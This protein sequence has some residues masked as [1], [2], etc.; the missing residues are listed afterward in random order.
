[1]P[2]AFTLTVTGWNAMTNVSEVDIIPPDGPYIVYNG[3]SIDDDILGDN[4]GQLDYGESS[5]LGM[6]LENVGIEL[7]DNITAF[8]SSADPLITIIQDEANFGN[9]P[10]NSTVTVDHAY[11][12][13]LSPAVV[14]G[15]F[16]P[17]TLTAN[18][19]IDTWESNFSIIAHAPNVQYS[20]L[21]IDDAVGGNGNGSLDPGESATLFVNVTN[22]GSSMMSGVS[23]ILSTTDPHVI[24]DN[25]TCE[26]LLMFAPGADAE[27]MFEI[28]VSPACPQEHGVDFVIDIADG[29][30]GYSGTT[31][32][33]TVVGNILFAPTGPDNYG[34]LAYDMYDFPENPVYDWVE[35][36]ADS[37][38]FGTEAVFT[39]DDQNLFFT[40]P[41]TFTFYGVDYD[42]FT[43]SSN[44]FIGMGIVTDTDYSNSG[45]PNSD[46]PPR[47]IAPYW[48]DLSPQRAN[49]GGVWTY[50]DASENIF[51]IEYNHVEQ[52]APTGDFETFQAIL[53]DPAHY[54]TMTGDGRIKFQYKEMSESFNEEG[55]VGI[56]NA[57]ETD[58]I[59]FI[60]DGDYDSHAFPVTN[61]Y[62]VLFTTATDAPDIEITLE[63]TVT[64][65]I[66]IPANGG[67]FSFD[68]HIANNGA[69]PAFFDGWLEIM[70]PDQTMYSVFLRDGISLG[71]SGTLFRAMNQNVPAGAP[72]GDYVYYARLGNHPIVVYAEDT[73][74]FSKSAVASPGQP[75]VNDWNVSGWEEDAD[76]IAALT[77]DSYYLDQNFPNPFNP[78]T[79]I[80][81]G[82]PENS[83]VSLKIYNVLGETVATLIDGTLPGGNYEFKWNAVEV[84]S[85]LYFYRLEA[86][87]F[88]QVK[89]MMLIR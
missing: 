46:G 12:V 2:G 89:K 40:L 60:Y 20:G 14:D 85:G 11:Q 68:L 29:G 35:I 77:P 30:A 63:P 86:E 80:R 19:G 83:R 62:A 48:E 28:T 84:S 9:I 34:Y 71:P 76:G 17:I 59:E 37:G 79:S 65:P 15:Q 53:Y 70:M 55:T 72:E 66:V 22:E 56:E 87:N 57:A 44:G 33:T 3:H 13:E 47:M 26:L 39:S 32:F 45:I 1:M 27:L 49:S 64:L 88:T 61:G 21:T 73:I 4:N 8:I 69:E 5:H 81:F 52:Y 41:F 50:Y 78:E 43:I 75:G 18:D 38:G 82:L 67:A 74:P 58:G 25:A 31:E 16:I 7:G 6:T 54:T 42:T 51:I 10:E 23:G 24:I 36:S